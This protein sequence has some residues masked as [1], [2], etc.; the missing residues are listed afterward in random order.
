MDFEQLKTFLEVSRLKSFSRAADKLGVTQ[1]A[2]SAQIRSLENEV[3][4]RLFDRDGGKVTFTA[5]GR[6]FEPFAEHCLQASNHIMVAIG[7]LHRSPRGEISISAN[8]ATSLYVLPVVFA[9]FKKQYTRVNLSIVRADRS[10][11]LEAVLNREVDFGVVSLPVKDPRLLIEVIHKDE[12]ALV[13]PKT[14]PLVNREQ[15]KFAELLQYPLLLPKHGRQREQID[16]LFR[17]HDVHPRVA[18]EVDSSE[19]LKRLIGAGLGMGFLPRSNVRD[20]ERAGLLK[21][22]KVEGV[23]LSRELALVFRKDK[24]LTRAAQAFLEIATGRA[25]PILLQAGQKPR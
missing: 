7:E 11:T 19:L 25:R 12:L 6:L 15:I 8:E 2:I 18:M 13:V 21:M 1:P 9:Q 17:T 23:R 14:H 16:D 20:D 22:L 3:G 10:R 24:T 5:A 4:A